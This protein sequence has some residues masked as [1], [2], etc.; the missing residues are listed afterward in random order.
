[1]KFIPKS[2]PKRIGALPKHGF[3]N[4]HF[5]LGKVGNVHFQLNNSGQIYYKLVLGNTFTRLGE[6]FV[7]KFQWMFIKWL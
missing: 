3:S 5:K 6:N 7:T 4:D 1:M 2:L